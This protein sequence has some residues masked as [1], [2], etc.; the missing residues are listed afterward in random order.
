MTAQFKKE[1][2]K[3]NSFFRLQTRISQ[4][5]ECAMKALKTVETWFSSQIGRQKDDF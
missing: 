1:E 4:S 3:Y 2:E 5:E